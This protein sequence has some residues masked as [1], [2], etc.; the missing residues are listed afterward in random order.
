M[1]EEWGAKTPWQFFTSHPEPE[2]GKATAT[3]RI[4]E[5]SRMGW[6]P[7][8]VPDPQDPATFERSHLD[9][10]E[11][12]HPEHARLLS[13]YRDLAQLRR[14]SADFT[15][16]RFTRIHVNVDEEQRW[17]SLRRG[18]TEIAINFAPE[19]RM[20]HVEGGAALLSFAPEGDAIL[21]RDTAGLRLAPHSVAVLRRA[22]A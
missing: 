18:N 22:P 13:L 19:P 3:G 8:V 1:G 21:A 10:S 5:F 12:D 9:W 2:L 20:V 7:A 11:L 4:A 16:P 17:L 6:D 14:S 15:D